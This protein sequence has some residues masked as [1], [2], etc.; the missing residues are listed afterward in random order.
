MTSER[1][2][3]ARDDGGL[4]REILVKTMRHDQVWDIWECFSMSF[5]KAGLLCGFLS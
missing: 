2:V 3:Q 5:I 4:D 1:L